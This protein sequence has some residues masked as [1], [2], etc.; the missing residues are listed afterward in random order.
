MIPA[1]DV[2][3]DA[4]SALKETESQIRQHS[5]LAGLGCG[6]VAVDARPHGRMFWDAAPAAAEV[7]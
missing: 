1:K 6:R 3:R 2:R 7:S 5:Y 4:K